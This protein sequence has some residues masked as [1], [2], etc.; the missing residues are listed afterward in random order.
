MSYQRKI[1][2]WLRTQDGPRS[3]AQI[4]AGIGE[5]NADR[6]SYSASQMVRDG[7]M[8][9]YGSKPFTYAVD[10]SAD[11][12]KP[13]TDEEK[14]K[15]RNERVRKRNRALGVM[16]RA[17]YDAKRAEERKAKRAATAKAKRERVA[18]PKPAP[19]PA[20]KPIHVQP[21]CVKRVERPA[22]VAQ[23]A[24]PETV[25]EFLARGGRIERLGTTWQTARVAFNWEPIL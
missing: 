9:R 5:A 12:R 13:V 19:K 23:D 4:A 7:Q 15:R 20:P 2:D 1:R 10:P 24:E 21:A 18:K 14:R 22:P 17:E 16:S 8:I 6:V 25:D 3:T 11:T